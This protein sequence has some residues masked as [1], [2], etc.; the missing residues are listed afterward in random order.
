MIDFRYHLVSII[1]IFLALAVGIVLGTAALTGPIQDNFTG[2]ITRLSADKRVLEGDVEQLRAEL[3]AADEF[4]V[5]VAP[6]LVQGTLTD[7]D[8][9]LVTT[10]ETPP[11]LAERL[12][13][14]LRAAGAQVTGTL[15]LLPALSDRSSRVL[16]EDLVAQVVPA[17]VELP[18]GEPVE[19]ATAELAA[20]LVRPRAGKGVDPAEAQAVVSAFEEAELVR[21]DATG[22]VLEQADLAV[23]LTGER[24]QAPAADGPAAD[25]R[26]VDLEQS[27]SEQQQALLGLVRELD[28]RSD[29]AVA[30][31]PLGSAGDAGLL[32]LLR[33]EP[34]VARAVSSVDNADRGAGLVAV[35][36]A[37]AQPRAGQFGAGEGATAVL[38]AAAP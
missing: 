21:F 10:P 19:R 8:V 28:A 25:G 15:Q 13:P 1:A 30:A 2:N 20:A 38:P 33:A 32:Q 5:T 22:E 24:A 26:A 31:G 6:R 27:W 3:D 17:G 36:L 14:V 12:T 29:G 11:D 37:L 34:A 7:R 18:E 35:V 23:V 9:L 4:A 16:V